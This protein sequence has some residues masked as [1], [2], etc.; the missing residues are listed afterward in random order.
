MN[1]VKPIYH[2]CV[3]SANIK[4]V[5]RECH[6]FLFLLGVVI[7]D[8]RFGSGAPRSSAA[9]LPSITTFILPSQTDLHFH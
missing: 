5:E 2:V 8:D 4:K 9:S 3:M 6:L 1:Y 7:A